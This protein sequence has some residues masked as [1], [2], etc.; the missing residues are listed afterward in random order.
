MPF[1]IP[2]LLVA[3]LLVGAC[4]GAP[5]APQQH[6]EPAGHQQ[7]PSVEREQA[8]SPDASAQTPVAELI[9]PTRESI[10]KNLCRAVAAAPSGEL[11]P[12][13]ELRQHLPLG[14]GAYVSVAQHRPGATAE[15]RE[16][17]GGELGLR[18]A[19]VFECRS[20][21]VVWI[22]GLDIP[23]AAQRTIEA[24]R[25]TPA[26]VTRVFTPIHW[27]QR[28]RGD[29]I[30]ALHDARLWCTLTSETSADVPQCMDD[31]LRK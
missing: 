27:R 15:Y 18:Y 4:A 24:A 29:V 3:V 13:D 16:Y 8:P 19:Q 21:M 6:V 31:L 23:S 11:P 12:F 5:S 7:V 10:V 9:N 20:L 30:A 14:R 25:P 1:T 22:P 28:Y 26:I 17:L 2:A